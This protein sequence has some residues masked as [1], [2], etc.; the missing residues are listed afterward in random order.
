MDG[1]SI[2]IA[3]DIRR[4]RQKLDSNL[5]EL[6]ERA[7][8]LADWRIHYRKHPGVAVA[9]AVGSGLVL[10]LLVGRRRVA[11]RFLQDFEHHG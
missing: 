11:V 6:E 8:A 3:Q 1:Q 9:V 5:Q 2:D 10:G 4:E 7:T